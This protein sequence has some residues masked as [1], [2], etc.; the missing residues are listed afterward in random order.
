MN[1]GVRAL[2]ILRELL[3]YEG[4]HEDLR[5]AAGDRAGADLLN[6][7]DLVELGGAVGLSLTPVTASMDD[8]AAL[9]VPVIAHLA[10]E[11][12]LV[13]EYVRP[14]G[15]VYVDAVGEV[16]SVGVAEHATVASDYSG[17][18][19]VPSLPSRPSDPIAGLPDVPLV[20]GIE[21]TVPQYTQLRIRNKGARDLELQVVGGSCS[22]LLITPPSATVPHAASGLFDVRISAQGVSTEPTPVVVTFRSNAPGRALFHVGI[23]AQADPGAWTGRTVA[24]YVRAGE[25]TVLRVGLVVNH[26]AELVDLGTDVEWAT[27]EFVQDEDAP[28]DR[29]RGWLAVTVGPDAPL[30]LRMVSVAAGCRSERSPKVQGQVQVRVVAPVECS[31]SILAVDPGVTRESLLRWDPEEVV[32][33]LVVETEGLDGCTVTYERTGEGE[34]KLTI[35]PPA[36]APGEVTTGWVRLRGT[37]ASGLE[38]VV[39]EVKVHLLPMDPLTEPEG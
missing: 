9:D 19:L 22:C 21:P 8:L 36:E 15:V 18:A 14:G 3:G 28:D 31:P 34:G 38:R 29:V 17:V 24:G 1:C 26:P 35:V 10:T 11:H 16:P 23:L 39:G 33:D 7:G 4:R 37:L 6:V 2:M 25:T 12:F 13:I 32:S 5:A 27:A 30:G 20:D